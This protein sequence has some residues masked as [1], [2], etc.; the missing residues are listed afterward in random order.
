VEL[1]DYCIKAIELGL[2]S[3]DDPFELI[4]NKAVDLIFEEFSCAGSIV[5]PS[6][7]YGP[8]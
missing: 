1:K 5:T 3:E 6:H 4:I 2:V 7:G 8:Q